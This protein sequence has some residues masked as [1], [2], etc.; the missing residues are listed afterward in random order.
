MTEKNMARAD[1]YTGVI[2]MA[3]GITATVM[4]LQMP[5]IPKDPYSAPGVLPIF[6]GVIITGLS[7]VMFV[8]SLIKTKGKVGFS[9]G[10]IKS[11]FADIGTRRVIITA[12]LCVSY[13]LLL[14]KV[15]FP[16]LTF[17]FVFM[18][19][20]IFECDRK[21][22]FRPQIKKVLIAALIAVLSAASI[23]LVFEKLFLVRLP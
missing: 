23:T 14:G 9:G 16:P 7:L 3:F 22:P 5:S 12:V 1:F 17:V 21:I 6:L 19:I 10:S 18:F 2:M 8:R 11:F 20:V 4:A 13:A 15:L